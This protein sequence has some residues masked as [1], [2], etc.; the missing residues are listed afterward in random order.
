MCVA[1]GV[2]QR[3]AGW[4]CQQGRIGPSQCC[5]GALNCRPVSRSEI[6]DHE[7]NLA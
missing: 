5:E 7:L 6:S 3:I 4:P 1:I 2:W